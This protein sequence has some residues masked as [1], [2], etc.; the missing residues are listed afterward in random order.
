MTLGAEAVEANPRQGL[1]SPLFRIGDP[2]P[3]RLTAAVIETNPRRPNFP[4]CR[5]DGM[6]A[7]PGPRLT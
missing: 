7:E 5:K 3:Q 6:R 1:V 4:S 2:D